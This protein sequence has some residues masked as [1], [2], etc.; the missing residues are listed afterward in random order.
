[1]RNEQPNSASVKRDVQRIHDSKKYRQIA[2]ATIE[3]IV[4]QEVDN[5]KKPS[6]AVAAAKRKLHIS[7][8]L[9]LQQLDYDAARE[10]LD[11]AFTSGSDAEILAACR[12]IIA[13]HRS[14]AE[15]LDEM[16]QI[17]E[18]IYHPPEGPPQT[19]LDLACALNPLA[20]RWME[21]PRSTRYHAYDI[22][23]DT[24]NLVNHYFRLEG[25]PELAEQRD[26]LCAP[27]DVTADLAVLMKTYHCFDRRRRGIGLP[28]LDSIPARRFVVTLPRRNLQGRLADIAGNYDESIRKLAAERSWQFER[29]DFDSEVLLSV[30]KDV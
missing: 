14:S 4:R 28:L 25:L 19:V 13:A 16:K 5:Y 12:S 1:M 27:P 7:A 18:A 17:Y 30:R 26:V 23:L 2:R 21:L 11:E 15:R 6:E 20:F 3:D 22:N 24:V 29:I 10:L 8:G 9:Y